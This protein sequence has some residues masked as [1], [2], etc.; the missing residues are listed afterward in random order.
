MEAA[1]R[2][3]APD[4]MAQAFRK[5]GVGAKTGTVAKPAAKPAPGAAKQATVTTG[6]TRM[7]TK[8]DHNAINWPA[9]ARIP[10]KKGGD[11]KFILRDG[12]KVLYQR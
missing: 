6:F 1:I 9:T 4:A 3:K 5:A 2:S 10:G 8:P 11:G 7:A 12:S